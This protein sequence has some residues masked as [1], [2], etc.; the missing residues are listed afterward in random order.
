MATIPS[1]QLAADLH[2]RGVTTALLSAGG[3]AAE[4]YADVAAAMKSFGLR[5]GGVIANNEYVR[6][7]RS[8]EFLNGVTRVLAHGD[9]VHLDVEPHT[10]GDFRD[11]RAEY[12]TALATI[13]GQA[14]AAASGKPVSVAVPYWY[15]VA[16]MVEIA[17]QCDVMHLM[18][19]GTTGITSKA[20]KIEDLAEAIGCRVVLTLRASDFVSA[21]AMMAHAGLLLDNPA[22]PV[23]VHEYLALADLPEASPKSSRYRYF[24]KVS[25]PDAPEQK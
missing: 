1:A 16:E 6:P 12:I 15:T 25:R 19:Y 5:V 2:A 17:A 20:A 4:L 22:I 11:K 8:Q 14:K 7:E 23:S 21:Q 18:T 24:R 10:L 3:A 9:E 13:A